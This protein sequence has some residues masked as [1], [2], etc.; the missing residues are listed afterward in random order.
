[1]TKK[2]QLLLLILLVLVSGVSV[3]GYFV[4]G[5]L[6]NQRYARVFATIE[7]SDTVE[8]VLGKMGRPARVNTRVP[9]LWWDEKYLGPNQGECL[10]EFSYPAF[11]SPQAW[12]IGFDGHGRVVAKSHDEST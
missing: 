7:R 5:V 10:Q 4:A 2:R 6:R 12:A 11:M 8:T 9:Y 1:M 3:V